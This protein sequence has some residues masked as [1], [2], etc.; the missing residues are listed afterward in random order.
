LVHVGERTYRASRYVIAAGAQPRIPPIPG[1]ADAQPLTSTT[2]MDVDT[3]P[4]A[5]TE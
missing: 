4:N 3:L 1:L 5:S 2:L